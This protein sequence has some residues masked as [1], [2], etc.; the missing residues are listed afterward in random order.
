MREKCLRKTTNK[1]DF[2]QKK[3]LT[4]EGRSAILNKLSAR[5]AGMDESPEKTLKKVEKRA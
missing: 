2:F 5:V 4:N 1:F 3:V